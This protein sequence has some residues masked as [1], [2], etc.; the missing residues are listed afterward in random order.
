MAEILTLTIVLPDGREAA[1]EYRDEITDLLAQDARLVLA[2]TSNGTEVVMI[3]RSLATGAPIPLVAVLRALGRLGPEPAPV[4]EYTDGP[5]CRY[6]EDNG[7]VI[8]DDPETA[9]CAGCL[10][11]ITRARCTAGRVHWVI[12]GAAWPGR[13]GKVPGRGH[14]PGPIPAG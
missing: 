3:D 10:Q 5:P 4:E 11:V 6:L 2:M 8:E 12:P 13:C 9:T 14:R 7:P 1:L